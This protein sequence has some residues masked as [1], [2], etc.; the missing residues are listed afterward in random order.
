[1]VDA[2]RF[3]CDV[4]RLVRKEKNEKENNKTSYR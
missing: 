1:M 3:Y 2:K 4:I